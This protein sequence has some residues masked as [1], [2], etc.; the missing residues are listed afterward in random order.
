MQV[1]VA[2]TENT[3]G[4]K[5]WQVATV[6][7]AVAA[8]AL[9]HTQ[10]SAGN[11]LAWALILAASVAVFILAGAWLSFSLSGNAL[12]QV[13]PLNIVAFIALAIVLALVAPQ[14]KV[15]GGYIKL[16]YLHAAVTWVGLIL[17][18]VTLIAG[19][20]NL[21]FKRPAPNWVDGLFTNALY[22]WT[23]STLIG[24][25]AAY[26]TWGEAW[27]LEPRTRM[28]FIIF[29]AGA[30]AYVVAPMFKRSIERVATWSAVPTFAYIM[31]STTGKLVHPNNAFTKSDSVEIKIFALIIT[32]VFAGIA[33][34]GVRWS[35]LKSGARSEV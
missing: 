13:N 6:Y 19:I 1:T 29:T 34:Q 28:A 16:I 20:A 33:A 3:A 7:T 18:A 11:E 30:V 27:Y 2:G 9:I 12:A 10:F 21:A 26:L 32:L 17:F 24:S 4:I 14:E 15:L 25:V 35:A 8:V 31:L 23:A 22:F 5:T